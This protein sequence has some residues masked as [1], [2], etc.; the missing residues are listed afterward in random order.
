MLSRAF[1]KFFNINRKNELQFFFFQ[2]PCP[3]GFLAVHWA[4]PRLQT[5]GHLDEYLRGFR[6]SAC[7]E[8]SNDSSTSKCKILIIYNLQQQNNYLLSVSSWNE[9]SQVG[10]ESVDPWAIPWDFGIERLSGCTPWGKVQ[11]LQFFDSDMVNGPS[12]RRF[13][14]KQLTNCDK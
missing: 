14:F 5:T 12:S 4:M 6:F 3:A 1:L 8:A 11:G 9:L 2:I 13:F 7:F 10:K